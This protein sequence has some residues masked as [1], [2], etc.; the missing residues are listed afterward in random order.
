MAIGAVPWHKAGG[1]P[2]RAGRQPAH[3]LSPNL[4]ADG[5]RLLVTSG[6][7]A[8][9]VGFGGTLPLIVAAAQAVGATPGQIASGV[10]GL[11][12]S[13]AFSTAWLGWR[14][15][16]PIIAAW[17]TPGGALIAG[18]HGLTIETVVAAYLLAGVL[19]LV[20]AAV[21]PLGALVQRLPVAIA[22]AMLAGVL[23]RFC[24][25][26]FTAGQADPLLV[27]PLVLI[28]L[29][30]RRI[31]PFGGVLAVLVIGIALAFFLGRVG[32]LPA[33]RAAADARIH[34]AAPRSAVADRRRRAALH[35]HHGLAEPAGL[36][37]AA[38]RRLQ[39]RRRSRSSPR[40]R[41]PRSSPRRSAR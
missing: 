30:A 34:R 22:A 10:I 7:V 31:S 1:A 14:H 4:L 5:H 3:A 15:R 29:V 28:F 40:R 37:R 20:T 8:A 9:L 41:S 32:P 27:L 2:A 16:M 35:R 24:I 25:A 36:R 18:A 26:V 21:K 12:L 38:G 6:V 39:S 19:L 13:M 11:C 33:E 23:F 17:S